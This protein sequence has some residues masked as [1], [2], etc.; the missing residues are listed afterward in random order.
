[1]PTKLNDIA[2][3]LVA[4]CREGKDDQALDNLYADN[5]V[6]VEATPM[7]GADSAEMKGLD[8][9]RGKHEWWNNAFEVHSAEVDGPFL[10]GDNRF[11]V[12]FAMD[13]TNK[14]TKERSQMKEV[15]VYTVD[16]GKI[17]REEFYYNM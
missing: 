3:Q 13:T 15:G 8:A 4:Y 12:I 16:N 9:I 6:S 1:M 7:P 5:A 17:V 2:N 11:G 14:E 10:H